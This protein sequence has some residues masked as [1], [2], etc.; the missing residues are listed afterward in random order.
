MSA[1]WFTLTSVG[2]LPHISG[3]IHTH[4]YG[5]LITLMS[6]NSDSQARLWAD[7][8][9][10]GLWT[11]IL[12][13][14]YGLLFTPDSQSCWFILQLVDSDSETTSWTDAHS[15]LCA[16]FD[17]CELWALIHTHVSKLRFILLSVSWCTLMSMGRFTLLSMAWFTLISIG[18]ITWLTLKFVCPITSLLLHSLSTVSE[19]RT[20]CWQWG[21]SPLWHRHQQPLSH[22]VLHT[23]LS[24]DASQF[25]LQKF[26]A[27]GLT[28]PSP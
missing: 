28:E 25:S 2:S 4:V 22:A 5:L 14:A 17:T 19:G 23:L 20:C 6:V 21:G 11:L 12:T 26:P 24:W 15:H 10:Y 16:D 3:L 9:T 13:H 8:Q 1:T 7:S 18:Y 27:E